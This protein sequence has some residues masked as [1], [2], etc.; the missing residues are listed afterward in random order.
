MSIRNSDIFSE[1]NRSKFQK[2]H[3]LGEGIDPISAPRIAVL[4]A[5]RSKFKQPDLAAA[6]PWSAEAEAASAAGNTAL[7]AGHLPSA[8]LPLVPNSALAGLPQ[9][10]SVDPKPGL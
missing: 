9:K 1:I 7:E 5:S 3:L 4:E 10:V 6:G 2:F 8:H